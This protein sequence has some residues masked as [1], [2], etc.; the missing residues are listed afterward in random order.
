MVPSS[1]SH[2]SFGITFKTFITIMV[3]EK[4]KSAALANN[5]NVI[6]RQMITVLRPD[7]HIWNSN[8]VG[9]PKI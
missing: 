6:H 2:H 3:N 7:F 9:T 8:P 4:T 5:T 1:N